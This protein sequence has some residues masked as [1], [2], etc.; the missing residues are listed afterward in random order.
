MKLN[1]DKCRVIHYK[2]KRNSNNLDREYYLFNADG[3]HNKI[4]KS[5][6]E[7]DLEIM[8]LSDLKWKHQ[9]SHSI[10]KARSIIGKIRNS[11]KYFDDKIVKIIYPTFIRP[12]IEYAI[13][14][15]NP[16]TKIEI[17]KLKRLQKKAIDR[18]SVV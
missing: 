14:V 13:Q 5:E 2:A 1:P 17:N 7:R 6:L 4:Q 12:H 9:T 10:N 18:K 11:F 3:T 8:I 16:Q 15:W